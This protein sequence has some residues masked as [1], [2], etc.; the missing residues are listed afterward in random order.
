MKSQANE[1]PSYDLST[2]ENEML[3]CSPADVVQLPQSVHRERRQLVELL[4][5]S[6]DRLLVFMIALRVLRRVLR[7]EL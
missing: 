4:R 1:T 2:E 5:S 3:C 7:R 6:C